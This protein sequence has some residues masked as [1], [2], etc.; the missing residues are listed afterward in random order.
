MGKNKGG[1]KEIIENS[2][3]QKAIDDYKIVG[4]RNADFLFPWLYTIY[5]KTY[6]PS[7]DINYK[8]KLSLDKTKLTIFD[9]L[10]DDLAD[11]ARLR[12]KK[13]LE[14][15]IRIPWNNKLNLENNYLFFTKKIW[16]DCINS[17]KNYPRYDEFRDIFYFDLDQVLNSMRY[18]YL[19]N[20]SDFSSVIEDEMYLNH[21]VMVILHS[22]MDLMCSPNFNYSEL[23][24]LRPIL[25][26]VQDIAHIGNMMNTYPKEIA[27]ADFS[28]PIISHGIRENLIKKSTVINHPEKAKEKLKPLVCQ[29]E[30]RMED[31]LKKIEENSDK[32]KSID[33]YDFSKRLKDVWYAF[34]EREEYWLESEC[35]NSKLKTKLSYNQDLKW[36]RM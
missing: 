27:E 9:V 22:D 4:P 14:E 13:L 25:H 12:N 5:E 30:K 21:G 20:T 35:Y 6:L 29:Y 15:A 24:K 16:S 18:S 33:I 23:N 26:W 17:I 10:I 28:S 19:V 3:L 2:E 11:N 31:N 34:I 36:V 32:I 8:E 7:I 1:I